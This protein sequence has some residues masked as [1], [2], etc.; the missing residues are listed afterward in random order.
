[1]K[2][3]LNLYTI[4]GFT[5]EYGSVCVIEDVKAICKLHAMLKYVREFRGFKMVCFKQIEY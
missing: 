4:T 2:I 3:V 5:D 1:M